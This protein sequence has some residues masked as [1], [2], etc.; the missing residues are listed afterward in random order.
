M[1]EL[2]DNFNEDTLDILVEDGEVDKNES[3]IKKTKK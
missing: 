1:D 2:Q 3:K